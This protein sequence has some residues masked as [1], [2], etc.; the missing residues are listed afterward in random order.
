MVTK[1]A[2]AESR[3]HLVRANRDA[4]SVML[5]RAVAGGLTPADAVVLIADQRDSVGREMANA[6]AEKAGLDA[7]SEA[8]RVQTRGQI[9]T[10]IIVMPLAGARLLFAESHPE[11]ARVLT[12]SPL[13]GRVRVV[14]IA[15]GA[16][17]LVHA[18]ASPTTVSLA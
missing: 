8:E 9:P 6:A 16:A 7:T 5:G 15:Q 13:A 11:V 2:G 18:E 14:A 1:N 17:M 4:I 10:A 3:L 12:R